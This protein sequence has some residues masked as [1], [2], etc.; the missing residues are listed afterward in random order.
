MILSLVVVLFFCTFVVAAEPR[1]YQL[2]KH[3]NIYVIAHRGVHHGIPENTL[4]AYQKAIELGA[5]FVEIDVR[6][7]SKSSLRKGWV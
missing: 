4:P 5:D 3:G 7:T 1:F 2:P 6:T